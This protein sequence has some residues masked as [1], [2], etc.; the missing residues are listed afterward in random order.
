MFIAN[1]PIT[2]TPRTMS[3]VAM[4]SVFGDVVAM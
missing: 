1:M 3:S 2:A 4:R